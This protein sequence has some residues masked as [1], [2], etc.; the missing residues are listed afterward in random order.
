MKRQ[1]MGREVIVAVT[2]GKLDFSPWSKSFM[3]V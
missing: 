3:G 1:I 2:D